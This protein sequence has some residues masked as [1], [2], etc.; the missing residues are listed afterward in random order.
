[1]PA[2]WTSLLAILD[3]CKSNGDRPV[4]VTPNLTDLQDAALV[5]F[6]A[7]TLEVTD[8]YRFHDPLARQMTCTVPLSAVV[9]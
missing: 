3:D 2:D 1:M 4:V 8:E 6:A 5:R 9:I 7:D